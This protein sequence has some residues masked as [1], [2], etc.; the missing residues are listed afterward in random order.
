MTNRALILTKYGWR[1]IYTLNKGIEV[2]SLNPY[3]NDMEFKPIT[4]FEETTDKDLTV[5]KFN[6]YSIRE[7]VSETTNYPLFSKNDKFRGFFNIKDIVSFNVDNLSHLY[8]TRLGNWNVQDNK[9]FK[10][11][12][13]NYNDLRYKDG[14]YVFNYIQDDRLLPLEDFMRFIGMYLTIGGTYYSLEYVFL[15]NIKPKL[16]NDIV[17]ILNNLNLNYEVIKAN[18][19]LFEDENDRIFD[20]VYMIKDPSLY[21]Y[22]KDLGDCYTNYIPSEIKNQ[23]RRLLEIF[24]ESY[25]KFETKYRPFHGE[26]IR[27]I[28]ASK[29]LILDFIEVFMKLGISTIMGEATIREFGGYFKNKLTNDKNTRTKDKKE[30]PLYLLNE[31]NISYFYMDKRFLDITEVNKGD[32]PN[33]K[34]YSMDNDNHTFYIMQNGRAHW[35]GNS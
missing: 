34:T 18:N 33:L 5:Y 6:Q 32:Y 7:M 27:A 35:I 23:S 12:K 26:K 17:R 4:K 21:Y 20:V 19:D 30:K 14:Y 2:L 16:N 8:L 29:R 15:Y 1:N 24:F 28:S 25:K 22:L 10:L 31:S 11:K 3:T 9:Y 13:C